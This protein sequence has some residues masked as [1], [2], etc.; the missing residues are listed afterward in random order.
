MSKGAL[1]AKS[2]VC[3]YGFPIKMFREVLP[4]FEFSFFMFLVKE[5]RHIYGEHK[6]SFAYNM[7]V[8][9]SFA[10]Y[11]Q[12]IQKKTMIQRILMDLDSFVKR[13]WFGTL[14]VLQAGHKTQ[15]R[16]LS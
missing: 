11:V 7:R 9:C 12:Y 10:F 16:N 6:K 2:L 15:Y 4:T 1:G 8:L 14:R 5:K 13:V 3:T